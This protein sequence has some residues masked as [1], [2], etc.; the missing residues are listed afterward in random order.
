MSRF[1]WICLLIMSYH[2]RSWFSKQPPTSISVHKGKLSCRVLLSA[3]KTHNSVLQWGPFLCG[4]SYP[5]LWSICTQICVSIETVRNSANFSV[6]ISDAA[7]QHWAAKK[8]GVSLICSLGLMWPS[9][10]SGIAVKLSSETYI[11][12]RTRKST[13]RH[14]YPFKKSTLGD[15]VR[16][17]K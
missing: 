14:K 6:C 2:E 16:L 11:S 5:S 7:S 15:S 13:T 12:A 8:W 4:P 1:D 17:V 10:W 9:A 3:Q